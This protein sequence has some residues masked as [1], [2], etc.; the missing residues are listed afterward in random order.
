MKIIY[1]KGKEMNDQEIFDTVAEHLFRQ[2]TRA[3]DVDQGCLYRGPNGT[4]CAVGCLIRDNDYTPKMENKSVY[5]LEE[6]G[7]LPEYLTK[8]VKLMSSL[9]MVHD[10]AGWS[11]RDEMRQA[12]E[13]VAGIFNLDASKIA[14]QTGE[15]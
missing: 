12:L 3:Y 2:G 11:N 13:E 7:L 15:W 8:N 10:T 5:A 14:T 6:D 4:K 1:Q 9:Q